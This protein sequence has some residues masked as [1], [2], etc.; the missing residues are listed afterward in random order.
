MPGGKTVLALSLLESF[1]FCLLEPENLEEKHENKKGM[2][3]LSVLL[4]N[5]LVVSAMACR[6]LE[7]GSCTDCLMF[8]GE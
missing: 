1:A 6:S 3:A 2:R 8:I 5:G 7:P 4:L